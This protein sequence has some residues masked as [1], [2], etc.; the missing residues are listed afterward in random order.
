[1]PLAWE[2]LDRTMCGLGET[3]RE[4]RKQLDW[5]LQA[6]SK[7]NTELEL[8]RMLTD[9]RRAAHLRAEKVG[10]AAHRVRQVV[11]RVLWDCDYRWRESQKLRLNHHQPIRPEESWGQGGRQGVQAGSVTYGGGGP[12][13]VVRT[14]DKIGSLRRWTWCPPWEAGMDSG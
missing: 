2:A 12:Q 4:F 7:A 10:A 13:I 9:E 3:G 5:E 6:F 11:E 14:E 1:M 8:Y